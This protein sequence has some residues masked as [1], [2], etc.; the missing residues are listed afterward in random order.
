MQHVA[1]LA[2]LRLTTPACL[3]IG[4]FDGVHRGHQALIGEMV[5][6]A[7][8]TGRA[9]V[10]VTFYPHPSVVLR[11]R[12]PA[13]YITSPDERA[14]LLASLGVDFVVTHPFNHEVAA[15]T[16]TDFVERLVSV[17][18]LSELW[19]GQDFALGH[20]REGDV[21]FLRAAGERRGFRVNVVSPT[22]LDGE[23]VSS[24][25]IR[26]ALRDGAVEQVARLLGR[27]FRLSGTVVE[28]AKRGRAMGSPTANLAIWDEHASPAAGVYACRAHRAGEAHQAVTNI[29]HRP[30]FERDAAGLTIEAHLLD[31]SADLYGATLTLEFAA[32]L[33]SEMKFP[34]VDALRAQIQQD[35]V[36]ARHI[37]ENTR[38]DRQ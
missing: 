37:L 38:G 34:G 28:G 26:Q 27:S 32:R 16:A 11:G 22:L 20:N 29:G 33:R 5:S 14:D 15:I 3:T 6:H 18:R 2:D 17:A 23:V 7:H 19:C 13:F 30:T 1:A 25:R 9:A 10:V 35:I 21:E 24:T 36:A 31:F 4:A 8:A 12:R